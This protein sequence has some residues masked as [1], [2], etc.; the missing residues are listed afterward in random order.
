LR[1]LHSRHIAH[2]D[3]KSENIL[4]DSKFNLKLVDF[5]SARHTTDELNQPI[6]YQVSDAVGSVKCNAPEITNKQGEYSPEAI[7]IFAAGCFLF[8]L[9]MKAEPFKSSHMQD[10]HYSKLADLDHNKFWDIFSS[11]AAPSL[12]F[13]G[14]Q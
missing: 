6:T 3:I 10:Q 1:H 4:L 11:K 14:N 8:E 9:V 12:D 13:K 7:D 5:G 2:C